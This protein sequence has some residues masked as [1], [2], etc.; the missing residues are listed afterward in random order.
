[1]AVFKRANRKSKP[2]G[3]QYSYKA[4]GI[5]K[6]K[7]S[8]YKTRKE[9]KAAE[10]EYLTS[11]GGSVKID[12]VITFADWYDK[13]LHTYKIRSVSELTM[14]KYATSGTIIRNYFKGLKLIDLTRMI[15]QQFINNYIDDGY[16]HK[17]ARQ[18]V[19]KLH[20]HAHQAIMAAADEGLIRRDYAAHAELGGTAGRSEDT[21]FL[22]ADQFEKLRD[23]VD[24]FASPQRIA[25]MMVQ[26][27]IYS[28]ARLGEIG[29]LTWE[30][31]DEKKSTI[32][33]DK[34]FKYRF[35]IRGADGSW[36]DREKVFGPTKTPSSVRTIKVSPVLIASLHKLILADKI[37]AISNPYHLLFLG[38]TGLPIYSNGVNKELRR[39]LKHL[40]IERPGFGFHGL[41]H[42]H[43]SYLLYKGL[44]IQ[45]VSHRLGHE[46]VGITTKIYTHLLDAMTQKQDEKALNV[47]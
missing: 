2:W 36:P 5:S 6:Q 46:N 24:Q 38:P 32:S 27:A 35:V 42:T 8:F 4:D 21:K 34:T 31:I 23:Y 22:E 33:I 18:S 26:T 39:A 10:A 44:D 12:P 47:L 15:Y 41:R 28:G 20:S 13:W 3:F 25:L 30:D 40:G 29:G 7:T 17:H 45:Y 11:T 19:Q 37:K 16:G 14:T 43:G 1:M 9:A